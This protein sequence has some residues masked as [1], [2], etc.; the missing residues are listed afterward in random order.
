M[1]ADSEEIMASKKKESVHV[2]ART[3]GGWAVKKG[4]SSRASKTFNKKQDAVD[5]G[6]TSS[7]KSHSEF[8]IHG[9]DGRIQK[10][11]SHGNDPHPPKDRK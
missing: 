4:G 8:Y 7:R 5:W 6:R 10:K 3:D 2:V 1:N 9:K 11:A